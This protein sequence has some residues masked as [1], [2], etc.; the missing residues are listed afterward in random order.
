[1]QILFYLMNQRYIN[2]IISF[3]VFSEKW[4]VSASLLKGVEQAAYLT[5]E[6]TLDFSA[7][8]FTPGN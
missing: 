6:N 1:M 3:R 7:S 2:N 5:G 4:K 8:L